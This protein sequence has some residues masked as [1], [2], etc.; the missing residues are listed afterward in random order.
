[1]FRKIFRYMY[2][3]IYITPHV[4]SWLVAIPNFNI[5]LVMSPSEFM[6]AVRIHL[7]IPFFPF[8]P[9]SATCTC[10]QVLD[11]YG[12]HILGYHY[13]PLRIKRHEALCDTVFHALIV[14]NSG[15]RRCIV[16]GCIVIGGN[17]RC[18]YRV[19]VSHTTQC[20]V[21]R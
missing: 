17:Y 15:C 9:A 10:G 3:Y 18:G 11:A 21:S 6:V 4:G 16:I 5:G 1:M 19:L 14:D 8:P 2:I 20:I 13:G 12:D 7:G